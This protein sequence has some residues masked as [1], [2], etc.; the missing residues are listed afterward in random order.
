L[1][2]QQLIGAEPLAEFVDVRPAFGNTGA[3]FICEAA[4]FDVYVNA[5]KEIAKPNL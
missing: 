3:T 5:E 2:T 4:S 1:V